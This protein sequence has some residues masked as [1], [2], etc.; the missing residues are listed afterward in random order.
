MTSSPHDALDLLAARFIIDALSLELVPEVLVPTLNRIE[1][2][3]QTAVYAVQLESSVGPAA[4]LVYG[5]E[6]G[7]NGKRG[8][9]SQQRYATDLRTLEVAQSRNVPGPRLIASG[10]LGGNRFVL[11]TDPQTFAALAGVAVTEPPEGGS[12]RDRE[13]AELRRQSAE[14]LIT[15]LRDADR[16]AGRW[17]RAIDRQ[18]VAEDANTSG[19]S[20]IAF[21]DMETELALYLLG[22][23]GIRNILTL[24][25]T[26]LETAQSGTASF[27]PADAGPGVPTQEPTPIDSGRQARSRAT[28][29]E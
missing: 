27:V 12:D 5:Y 22:P 13:P 4:F 11:A 25:S 23:N 29:P 6:T 14:A 8:A 21:D 15:L 2:D 18:R 28:D 17:L 1:R 24:A 7:Q 10:E 20:V 19:S 9:E 3:D 16:Q 26:I